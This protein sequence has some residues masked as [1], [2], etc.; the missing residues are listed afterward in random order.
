MSKQLKNM[1]NGNLPATA[2]MLLVGL[3][4]GT[5]GVYFSAPSTENI[6]SIVRTEFDRLSEFSRAERIA[7]IAAA[8]GPLAEQI[9]GFGD[10]VAAYGVTRMEGFQR[11][12]AVETQIDEKS[13]AVNKR[14][15]S[16]DAAL[17]RLC[18]KVD[19]LLTGGVREP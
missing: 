18:D 7:Q 13:D 12:K 11:L 19:R 2:L 16:V 4:S 10:I 3:G 14:L 1:F 6:R 5:G 15:D 9:K 8:V 17:L